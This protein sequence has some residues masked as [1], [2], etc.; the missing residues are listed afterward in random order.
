MSVR[1]DNRFYSAFPA[2]SACPEPVEGREAALAA[3]KW[4]RCSPRSKI[5]FVKLRVLRVQKHRP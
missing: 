3:F 1:D 5:Y 4:I 2:L